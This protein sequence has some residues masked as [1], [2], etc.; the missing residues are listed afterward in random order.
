MPWSAKQSHPKSWKRWLAIKSH[1]YANPNAGSPPPTNSCK[2]FLVIKVHALPHDEVRGLRKF[3][4]QGA[5]RDHSVASDH[6]AVI[7]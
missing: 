6:L 5:V 7:P 1:G 4:G 2:T 3:V